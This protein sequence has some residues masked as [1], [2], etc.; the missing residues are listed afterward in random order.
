MLRNH[1]LYLDDILESINKIQEYLGDSLFEDLIR[2][3]MKIDAIVRNLEIIG[4]ASKNISQELRDK[5]PF[6]EWKKISDFRNILA[7]EYFKVD[8]EIMWDIMKNKIPELKKQIKA[9]LEKE[10]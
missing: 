1:K 10:K 5:Y 8:H 4:E 2:N 3:G 9:I 6:V 7:H